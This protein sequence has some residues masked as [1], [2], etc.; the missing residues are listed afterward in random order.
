MCKHNEDI[1]VMLLASGD[2][3]AGAEAVVYNLAQSLHEKK[4]VKVCVVLFNQGR[5][6]ELCKAA[7]IDTYILDEK[8]NGLV[9]LV[10]KLYQ[11][12]LQ[13]KPHIIHAHRYKEN[14]IGSVV[15]S[16][17]GFPRL[18]TTVHGISE[19]P[20]SWKK[21]SIM[22][23]NNLM[24]R[25][26]FKK[27][28]AVSDELS[29]YLTRQIGLPKYLVSRI[30]NG[31]SIDHS[32]KRKKKNLDTLIIGSAGRLVP[33]KNYELMVDIARI[34]CAQRENV[35]FILAGDGPQMP[36]IREKIS[37]YGLY[38]RFTLLGHVNDIKMIFTS[39]DIYINTSRHEGIPMTVLE[40]MSYYLPV[41]VPDVGGFPEII[42]QGKSGYIVHEGN[43]K[44]FVEVLINLIDSDSLR[45]QYGYHAR[46]RVEDV[47]SVNTMTDSYFTLYQDVISE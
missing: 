43:A 31:I 30:Y 33:V 8:Q 37:A 25:L 29:N 4:P 45:E 9:N 5:L 41:V 26:A 3:W 36:S 10:I 35:R 11:L 24:L 42:E 46:R 22:L 40:A 13:Y 34:I 19:V 28:V 32:I 39:L 7:G 47:F 27:A 12:T 20:D 16:I 15:A 2:L 21:R 18:V 23:I 6:A 17:A 44:A 14:F 38:D 1:R